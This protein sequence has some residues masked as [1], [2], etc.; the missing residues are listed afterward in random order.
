MRTGTSRLGG[1]AAAIG[2]LAT[3]VS[4]TPPTVVMAAPT[5]SAVS[6]QID[7]A[8]TGSQPGETLAPPLVK[9]WSVN[10]GVHVSDALIVNSLVYVTFT[11]R[12]GSRLVALNLLD[13][14]IAWGPIDLGGARNRAELSYD[15]GRVFVTNWNDFVMAFDAQTG[16]RDWVGSGG[17]AMPVAVNGIV[18]S[19]GHDE[20]TG[21]G[22]W[23][24]R[25]GPNEPPMQ[26]IGPPA[27]TSTGVYMGNTFGPIWD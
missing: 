22:S 1:V 5:T 16:A 7:P 2:M 10:L 14:T 12:P 21:A 15:N 24:P 11:S 26:F 17:N 27:V 8:H 19:G 20:A 6:W 18:Y 23:S 13:G 25:P 3:L 4:P 9:Q